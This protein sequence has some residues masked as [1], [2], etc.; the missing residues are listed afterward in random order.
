MGCVFCP[1]FMFQ[2]FSLSNFE[3]AKLCPSNSY[4]L[5]KSFQTLSNI[6]SMLSSQMLFISSHFLEY[7]CFIFIFFY[8]F[9]LF[10]YIYVCHAISFRC[11]EIL[12][13]LLRLGS[14]FRLWKMYII[15]ILSLSKVSHIHYLL[16]ASWMA[17][18]RS[19]IHFHS[20]KGEILIKAFFFN[21]I[22]LCLSL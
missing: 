14:S 15:T 2:I 6:L 11:F 21:F 10:Q 13:I 18:G 5:V 20:L 7:L 22:L 12:C 1:Q 16:F 4:I 17:V 8:F 9:P 19:F 3:L